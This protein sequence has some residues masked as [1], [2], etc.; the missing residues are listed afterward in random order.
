MSIGCYDVHVYE[1]KQFMCK[2]DMVSCVTHK[3]H[4]TDMVSSA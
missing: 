1:L 4:K 3:T 2:T